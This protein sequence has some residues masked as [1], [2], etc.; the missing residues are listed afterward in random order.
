L[1]VSFR[2]TPVHRLRFTGHQD[3]VYLAGEMSR[4]YFKECYIDGT[5]DFIFGEATAFFESC[6]I[7][8]KSDSFITAASTV[9]GN[10]H[11]FVFHRCDFLSEDSVE[12]VFLG[13]PWRKHAKTVLIQ[14]NLAASIAPSGWQVWSNKEQPDTTFYGEYQ[15]QG[16]GATP[17]K[18]ISWSHQLSDNE[19]QSMIQEV[20]LRGWNAPN[21]NR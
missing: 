11:G 10:P 15:S 12:Q 21:V 20:V 18:R 5:T 17:A 6:K 9:K 14:C 13:R 16:S 4:Q 7:L 3:T 2:G 1:T 19:A 8:A